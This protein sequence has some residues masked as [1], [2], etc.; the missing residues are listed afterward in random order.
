MLEVKQIFHWLI[1][2]SNNVDLFFANWTGKNLHFL[3]KERH[4]VLPN[5]KYTA[6]ACFLFNISTFWG[7]IKNTHFFS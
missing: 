4:G 6:K 7:F 2:S 1:F 3:I 5:K